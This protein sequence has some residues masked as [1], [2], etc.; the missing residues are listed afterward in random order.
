MVQALQRARSRLAASASRA[1]SQPSSSRFNSNTPARNAATPPTALADGAG[2]AEA[3]GLAPSQ[4]L[5]DPTLDFGKTTRHSLRV[6]RATAQIATLGYP[7]LQALSRKDFVGETLDLLLRDDDLILA[8]ALAAPS[9][10][11]GEPT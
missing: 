11:G 1:S 9:G 5:V 6:L 4:I 7:V 2:R 8:L 3:A 10:G